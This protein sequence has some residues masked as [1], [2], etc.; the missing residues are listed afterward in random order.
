MRDAALYLKATTPPRNVPISRWR[1]DPRPETFVASTRA[2]HAWIRLGLEWEPPARVSA[3]EQVISFEDLIRLRLIAL[4]RSRGFRYKHVRDAEDYVRQQFHIPQPFV[5]ERFWVAGDILVAF[6]DRLISVSPHRELQTA[7]V[8][9]A[10]FFT[11]IEHG[12]SFDDDGIADLWRPYRG[13]LIDPEIQF[14]SP[15]IEGTRVETEPLWAFHKAGDSIES[16]AEMY[17]LNIDRVRAALE[18]EQRIES[19]MAA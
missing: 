11:P 19:A 18:W 5:T 7:F 9:L 15:C 6:E 2:L 3:L 8:E 1:G 12:L 17:G 16:I 14:G 13:V 10:D 4:F